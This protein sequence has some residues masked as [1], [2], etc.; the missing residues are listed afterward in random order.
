MIRKITLKSI[1][2]YNNQTGAEFEPS[3]VNFMYGSNGSGKT[4]ISNVIENE[5]GFPTCI[6]DRGLNAKIKHLVYNQNFIKR[7][8]EPAKDLKGIFTLGEGNQTELNNI[9]TKKAELDNT[10]NLILGLNTTLTTKKSELE[11]IENRFEQECW[12]IYSKYKEIFTNAYTGYKNSKAN[13]KTK[14][15]TEFQCNSTPLLTYTVLEEKA[16]NI[17]NQDI[18]QLPLI[19]AFTSVDF[20]EFETNK[21][22]A[23]RIIGKDDVDIAKMILKL[24]NSDWVR[25]GI[26]YYEVNETACPFCQQKTDDNFKEQLDDYFD[27]TFL[28]QIKELNTISDKYTFEVT[29]ALKIFENFQT[30]NHK[31]IDYEVFNI[32]KELVETEFEKNQLSIQSKQKEPTTIIKIESIANHIKKLGEILDIAR[33][34]TIEHNLLAKNISTARRNAISEIWKFTIEEIRPFFSIYTTNKTA[35]TGAINSCNTKLNSNNKTKE[36]T[37]KEIENLEKSITNIKDTVITINKTLKSF[38]FTNFH[39]QESQTQKGYYE[40]IRANG[41][42]ALETLSEGEKTFLTFLYFYHLLNGSIDQSNITEDKIIVI[43]DPISSLDSSVLFIVS[44]LCRK[45]V[46]DC[47]NNKGNIKQVFLMTHNV[48]FHKEITFVSKGYKTGGISFWTV[49]KREDNSII[50]KHGENPIQTSYDLLWQEIRDKEN[51]NSLT[52][53]NTLRRILEYYFKILGKVKDDNL[54]NKF[55]GNDKIIGDSLMSWINDGSH[56]I[57]DDIYIAT[58][59]ETIEKYLEIFKRIFQEENQIEHYNMMM[60]EEKIETEIETE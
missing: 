19:S 26:K 21:I 35:I 53:F 3:L 16:N 23:T 1:A 13:F 52:I 32:T 50:R 31:Y 40:I 28:E 49:N 11:N 25:Q 47:Q 27:E 14:I 42:K 59:T 17:L 45:I 7:N 37:Q 56:L 5:T 48:Y 41:I 34:K 36:D 20:T 54:L 8:F 22:F 55:E 2:S 10:K 33:Q 24:N 6:I 38:G 58:D 39:L 44:N 60:R 4:T 29:S 51:I 9:I 43:D 57:N 30:Q 18:E 12:G 15:Q 46:S